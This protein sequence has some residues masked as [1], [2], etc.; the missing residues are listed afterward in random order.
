K[1]LRTAGG[2]LVR[3]LGTQPARQGAVATIPAKN[4]FVLGLWKDASPYFPGLKPP[5][6]ISEDGF[7]LKTVQRKSGKYWLIVGTSERGVLYGTFALLRY[8]AQKKD[9]STLDEV[10]NPSAPIRWA[11][12]WDNL[13]GSIER[14]YAG[15]SIFFDDG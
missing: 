15:R 5:H 13:D 7:W 14:G 3:A 12:E 11:S 1:V 10:Q 9:V 4:A 8:V 6:A 2:E